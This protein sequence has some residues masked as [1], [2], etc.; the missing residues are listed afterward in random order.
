MGDGSD[1]DLYATT[2][3]LV[4]L[5]DL[6]TR[7]FS[8]FDSSGWM[9]T[10][11]KRKV[12]SEGYDAGRTAKLLDEPATCPLKW[13]DVKDH[14]RAGYEIGYVVRLTWR[15]V[16]IGLAAGVGGTAALTTYG[17]TIL[18]AAFG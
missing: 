14:F 9:N 10:G 2:G 13:A 1:T 8:L 6:E 11:R 15:L 17:P 7:L 3:F 5:N 4:E 12:F 18:T 16:P